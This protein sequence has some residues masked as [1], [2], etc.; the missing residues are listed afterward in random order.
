LF[1]WFRT[2]LEFVTMGV[3]VGADAGKAH[4]GVRGAMDGAEYCGWSTT[5]TVEST[6]VGGV[7]RDCWRRLRRGSLVSE[8]EAGAGRGGG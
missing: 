7:V 1:K 4:P 3:T 6:E 8:R 2:L 5:P